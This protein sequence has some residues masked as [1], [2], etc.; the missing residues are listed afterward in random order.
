MNRKLILFSF[1]ILSALNVKAGVEFD[2]TTGYIRIAAPSVTQMTAQTWA[3]W[4]KPDT[5]G[6]G[7]LGR[8]FHVRDNVSGFP[9][10]SI[11]DSAAFGIRAIR[12][13]YGVAGAFINRVS[14]SSSIPFGLWTHIAVVF[15]AS[16]FATE[17]RF[18]INGLE[19]A[20][21]STKDSGAGTPNPLLATGSIY[22]ANRSDGIRT[23]DGTLDDL[24]V[25]NRILSDAEIQS[26]G[27]S[28][29]RLAITEGLVA[30]WRLD[31]QVDGA[32]AR[33]VIALDSSGNGNTGTGSGSGASGPTFRDG[34]LN[35]P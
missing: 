2:G 34:S 6:G 27:T 20:R 31:E 16:N 35:Y 9:S 33:G 22:I 10:I 29:C 18:F 5:G 4:I 23:F 8:V 28:S 19:V 26:L 24:R 7:N 12:L 25:Y 1:L 21:D 30:Y 13:E 15:D 11:P 3:A 17:P 32:I 14:I